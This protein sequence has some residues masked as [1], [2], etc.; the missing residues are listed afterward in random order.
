MKDGIPGLQ[1]LHWVSHLQDVPKGFHTRIKILRQLLKV[2]RGQVLGQGRDLF[3]E[4]RHLRKIPRI[5]Q[6]RNFIDRL[7]SISHIGGKISIVPMV[8][9]THV[10][11][12]LSYYRGTQKPSRQHEAAYRDLPCYM[13]SSFAARTAVIATSPPVLG[14]ED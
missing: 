13:G 2:S 6:D 9:R 7:P 11:R 12:L 5:D 4:F 10:V 8:V 14:V 1:G 3:R